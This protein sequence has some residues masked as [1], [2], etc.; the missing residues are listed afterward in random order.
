M[1]LLQSFSFSNLFLFFAPV[2]KCFRAWGISSL[3]VRSIQQFLFFVLF[4]NLLSLWLFNKSIFGI[5]AAL[6]A[7]LLV[8]APQGKRV[9][10]KWEGSGRDERVML[11]KHEFPQS[12]NI[13]CI[14]YW[15]SCLVAEK[16]RLCCRF[17]VIR[18]GDRASVFR[19]LPYHRTAWVFACQEVS[20]C[21]CMKSHKSLAIL[22]DL[23]R[24]AAFHVVGSCWY[25]SYCSHFPKVSS[26]S[27]CCCSANCREMW[28]QHYPGSSKLDICLDEYAQLCSSAQYT[29]YF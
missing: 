18:F 26:G 2:V 28:F 9:R 19:L 13:L 23:G 8:A 27:A 24:W 15:N 17:R 11:L 4:L 7:P 10:A 3:A 21:F 16:I 22:F 20:N 12:R 6:H 25:S 5:A 14:L 29:H 1:F